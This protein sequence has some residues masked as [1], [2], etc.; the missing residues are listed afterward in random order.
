MHAGAMH[1]VLSCV[2]AGRLPW[3]AGVLRDHLPTS[4]SGHLASRRAPG[5]LPEDFSP[6]ASVALHDEARLT[7]SKSAPTTRVGTPSV[8]ERT[9]S[10]SATRRRAPEEGK[11]VRITSTGPQRSGGLPPDARDT[12]YAYG[13][14]R[15]GA[16][17]SGEMLSAVSP[18]A[19]NGAGDHGRAGTGT[20]RRQPLATGIAELRTSVRSPA[21]ALSIVGVVLRCDT[22]T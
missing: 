10:A 21:L 2:P 18:E 14:S 6:A 12:P 11:E 5:P 17:S 19:G 20:V 9:H 16:C 13:T 15:S 1:P 22:P 7:P 3:S 8:T 4:R